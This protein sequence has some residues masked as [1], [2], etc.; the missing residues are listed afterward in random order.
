MGRVLLAGSF[1]FLLFFSLLLLWRLVTTLP[2]GE[3]KVLRTVRTCVCVC[4]CVCHTW[5][6]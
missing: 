6:C 3:A 1:V 4:V 2:V 5:Q